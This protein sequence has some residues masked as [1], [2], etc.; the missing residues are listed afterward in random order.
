[1]KTR[2][3]QSHADET[4]LN[5][6]ITRRSF[7]KRSAVASAATVFGM[8][9]AGFATPGPVEDDGNVVYLGVTYTIDPLPAD[10]PDARPI[11]GIYYSD[12]EL[13]ALIPTLAGSM[14][15]ALRY[16]LA[17]GEL[18][19]DLVPPIIESMDGFSTMPSDA[20]GSSDWYCESGS[21]TVRLY[22]VKNYLD[23]DPL[24]NPPNVT[25]PTAPSRPGTL[26]LPTGDPGG[27]PLDFPLF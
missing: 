9:N 13:L 25:P 7:V 24:Q 4:L 6:S 16:V 27:G 10:D 3:N 5:Q 2:N 21:V 11:D 26:P 8:A 22:E 19:V 14:T 20:P 18:I 23:F 15:N 1:M 12:E 17:D